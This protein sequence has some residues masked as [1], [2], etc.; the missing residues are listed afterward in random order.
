[1]GA[2]TELSSEAAAELEARE[3]ELRQ[4][5]RALRLVMPEAEAF[6][7]AR[8]ATDRI[9]ASRD[10]QE[11]PRIAVY[12]AVGGEISTAPLVSAARA[13]GK[14]V[15][16]PR[17]PS[18]IDVLEFAPFP[19]ASVL[20]IGRYGL[21]EPD[22]TAVEIGPADLVVLP[23]LAF[24]ASGRRLGAGGGWYDRTF[25]QRDGDAGPRLIGLAYHAQLIEEV[26][27]GPWDRCVDVVVTERVWI[28]V[29]RAERSE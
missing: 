20:R 1:M 2:R 19:S 6:A 12:L 21:P 14:S 17:V 5:M 26:P 29:A 27:H 22:G 23:G 16:L 25:G 3:A 13:A 8:E 9:V 11:A 7:A 10:F 4:R 18:G 28:R 24:D 15:L